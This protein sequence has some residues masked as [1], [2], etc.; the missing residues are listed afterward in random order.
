MQKPL[1]EPSTAAEESA[2]AG[3]DSPVNSCSETALQITWCC[4]TVSCK[5][6]EWQIS[7]CNYETSDLTDICESILAP[8]FPPAPSGCLL[9]LV[10][11]P[12]DNEKENK[13][14][15]YLPD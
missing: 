12:V 13:S 11:T 9:P 8:G 10:W 5:T 14:K 4:T 2:G 3:G 6:D 7:C 1:Q 15:F